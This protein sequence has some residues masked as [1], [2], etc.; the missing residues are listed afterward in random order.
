MPFSSPFGAATISRLPKAST[1]PMTGPPEHTLSR[2]S[3]RF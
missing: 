3:T 1:S 2:L